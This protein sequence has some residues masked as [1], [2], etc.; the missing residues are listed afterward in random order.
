MGN[1]KKEK[2]GAP[3]PQWFFSPEARIPPKYCDLIR[4]HGESFLD[5][6]RSIRQLSADLGIARRTARVFAALL[7]GESVHSLKGLLPEEKL[8]GLSK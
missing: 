2:S 4:Q 5:R 7:Q 1:P 8:R 3:H 6:P